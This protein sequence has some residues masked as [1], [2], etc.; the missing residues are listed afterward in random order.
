LA[1]DE[2]PKPSPTFGFDLQK[3]KPPDPKKGTPVAHLFYDYI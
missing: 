3:V 2:Q 1:D